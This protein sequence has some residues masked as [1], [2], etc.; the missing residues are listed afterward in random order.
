[1]L[2]L[3]LLTVRSL[4][5][6]ALLLS[7]A[8]QAQS[9]SG[10]TFSF[11]PPQQNFFSSQ[12]ASTFPQTFNTNPS[13]GAAPAPLTPPAAFP[14]T[15]ST[16]SSNTNFQ[17][18]Q[19]P[20]NG[21]EVQA[22]RQLLLST[23]SYPQ[24]SDIHQMTDAQL[25]AVQVMHT[26]WITQDLIDKHRAWHTRNSIGGLDGPGSGTILIGMHGAMIAAFE[27]YVGPGWQLPPWDPSTPIPSQL[28]IDARFASL[29]QRVTS[30]PKW[31]EPAMFNPGSASQFGPGNMPSSIAEVK[32]PDDLGRWFGL[33]NH[34]GAHAAVGGPMIDSS[35]S[36]IDP[37]FWLWHKR[38]H[39]EYLA[40]LQ[41]PNGQSW[42][43]SHASHAL[44]TQTT[45]GAI[46][47][48]KES[49]ASD[50]Y[51]GLTGQEPACQN[52]AYYQ[53]LVHPLG[54]QAPS[55]DL[56]GGCVQGAGSS[57][58]GQTANVGIA[59][60][61][62]NPFGATTTGFSASGSGFVNS[63]SNVG[64]PAFVLTG[65]ASSFGQPSFFSNSYPATMGMYSPA[66]PNYQ[67]ITGFP[68]FANAFA[69]VMWQGVVG[70]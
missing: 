17:F 58:F 7:T 1:M 47:C 43:A 67:P 11:G 68:A 6:S 12:P 33:Q 20:G 14:S 62:A 21:P 30:D 16:F 51:C 27:N 13:F 18:P 64:S 2:T 40:W 49:Y 3:R 24:I 60:S 65:S 29:G 4:Q 56:P 32:S 15:G 26:N 28:V 41:T 45:N 34:N 55:G 35:I 61:S 70:R 37:S 44:F 57:S 22:A 52:L 9:F 23:P 63:A 38:I 48:A 42:K 31:R 19:S 5:T 36:P 50:T 69:P 53:N 8:L 66:T 46:F 59:T 25:R 10:Q 39:T 54:A